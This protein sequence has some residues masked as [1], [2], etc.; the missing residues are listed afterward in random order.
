MEKEK[1]KELVYEADE[2]KVMNFLHTCT[3]SQALHLYAYNYNWGDG[4]DEPKAIMSNCSCSL[5]TA[6][7]LFYDADGLEFLSDIQQEAD[8]WQKEWLEFIKTLY[9]RIIKDDFISAQIKF[10][11]PLTKVE[12]YKLGKDLTKEELVLISSID[13]VNC[14]IQ[15]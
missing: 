14:N 1:I 10:E 15:L 2:E 5:S 3:D 6:L 9:T 8:E 12:L 4:F 7:Q 11:P 13:G